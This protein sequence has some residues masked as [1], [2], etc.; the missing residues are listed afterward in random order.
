MV[1]V[2]FPWMQLKERAEKLENWRMKQ[3]LHENKKKE[4]KDQVRKRSSMWIE[5]HELESKIFTAMVF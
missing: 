1:K 3:T 2:L 4:A 5:E